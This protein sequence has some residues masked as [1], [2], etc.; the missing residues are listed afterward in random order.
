MGNSICKYMIWI[1]LKHRQVHICFRSKVILLEVV[2]HE[3]SSVWCDP[4]DI[5]GN[6]GS[7][8]CCFGCGK[9]GTQIHCRK[10]VRIVWPLFWGTFECIY[11]CSWTFLKYFIPFFF[12][13]CSALGGYI[14]KA[15]PL[16]PLRVRDVF[17]Y[18]PGDFQQCGNSHLY[19]H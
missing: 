9:T 5:R 3:F 4:R 8:V 14:S 16:F 6:W 17:C 13:V 15:T 19:Q 18:Q 12:Q 2:E 11:L 10:N 7:I 1:H